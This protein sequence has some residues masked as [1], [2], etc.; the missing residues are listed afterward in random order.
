MESVVLMRSGIRILLLVLVVY[1]ASHA[2]AETVPPPIPE[3]ASTL[4]PV[5]AE[6]PTVPPPSAEPPKAA[7]AAPPTAPAPAPAPSPATTVP[8]TTPPAGMGLVPPAP[9]GAPAPP[10]PSA[11]PVSAPPVAAAAPKLPVIPPANST[12]P[13]TAPKA[14]NAA[15]SAGL[16]TPKKIE[17]SLVETE[18]EKA[19]AAKEA[20]KA[21]VEESKKD[22]INDEEKA[23]RKSGIAKLVAKLTRSDGSLVPIA[24]LPPMDYTTQNFSGISEEAIFATVARY[25]SF[26]IQEKKYIPSAL[27]LEQF[28]KVVTRYKVDVV[29]ICV[30][31]PTNLDLFLYDRRTPYRIYAHSEVLPETIQYNLTKELV[32]EY[33]KVIVRRT[34]YAYMQDQYFELPREE[35]PVLTQAEIPRWIASN[36]TLTEANQEILSNFYGSISV[37]GA[38]SVGNGSKSW[39]SNIVGLELGIRLIN[40]L[41]FELGVDFF[42]PQCLPGLN[43]IHLRQSEDPLPI[44]LWSRW[45]LYHEHPHA[46]LGPKLYPTPQFHLC[47]SQFRFHVSNRRH[48][49]QSRKPCLLRTQWWNGRYANARR[50]HAFLKLPSL[51]AT[52]QSTKVIIILA[53]RPR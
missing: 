23:Q 8:P 24:L 1:G 46:Q 40:N 12:L 26:N 43:K 9:P 3:G 42:F 14:P 33:T 20:E 4:P 19:E 34:L 38:F 31:K 50:L 21:K 13:T 16:T 5:Q 41:H 36:R 10:A 30:L 11:P 2:L 29:M 28:R 49:R 27:T 15:G 44:L 51:N 22:E 47:R 53:D 52:Q 37:G 18:E 48:P 39:S 25:G 32:E 17:S 45:R 35:S 6:S 7:A